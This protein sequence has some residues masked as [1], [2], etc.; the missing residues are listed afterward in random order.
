MQFGPQG[1]GNQ[2]GHRLHSRGSLVIG[3]LRMVPGGAGVPIGSTGKKPPSTECGWLEKRYWLG[4]PASG[5]SSRN[6]CDFT[7]KVLSEY[8][9]AN[10]AASWTAGT[11]PCHD[12]MPSCP[13]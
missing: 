12:G 8:H 6:D 13:T 4:A 2:Y 1:C 3:T 10:E 9:W 11:V 5:A 7:L